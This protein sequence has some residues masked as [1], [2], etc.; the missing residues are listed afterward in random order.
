MAHL[1]LSLLGPFQATLAG[2]AVTTFESDKDRALLAYL[3]AEADRP[4]RRQVLAALLWP[5][6]PEGEAR[7]HLRHTLAKLRTAVGDR[8]AT[9]PFLLIARETIQFNR[10][11][12]CWLDVAAFRE[13]AEAEQV[14]SWKEAVALYRGPFLEGFSL[15]DSAAFEDWSLLVREQLQRQVLATLHRL[16]EHYEGRGDYE[17]AQRYARRQV[18]LAPWYESAHRQLMR[19]LALDNQ[20]GAALAQY[21]ACRR[22]L[23]EELGVQP[24][25]ET[26]ALY[27]RIRDGQ[28]AKPGPREAPRHNLPPSLTPF[29]GREPELAAICARLRDPACRLLTLTGPGGCGKT[30]LALRAAADLLSADAMPEDPDFAAHGVFFVSL[31]SLHS[32]ETIVPTIAQ[33]LDLTFH[34]GRAPRQQLLDYLRQKRM[35]LVLDNFEHLLARPE[36]GYDTRSPSEATTLLTDILKAAPGVRILVTSRARL[37]LQAEQ[38]FPVGGMRFPESP[39]EAA[40]GVAQYGAVELF[41]SSARRAQ[42]DLEPTA[43]DLLHV[44]RICSL[45]QGMP[46][47]ILLAAAWMGMLSPAEIAAEIAKGLDILERD[48]RDVPQRHTSVRAVFGHSWNLLT[49][50]EREVFRGLSVFRGGFTRDAARQV[51]GA[52]LHVLTSLV[53]R[54][55]LHRAVRPGTEGRY[56]VHELLRQYAAEKLDQLPDA[57]EEVRDRHCAHYAS[58]LHGWEADLRGPRRRAAL[59]QI[60]A[61]VENARLAWRWAVDR[62]QVGR[63]DQAAECLCAFYHWRGRLQEGEAACRMAADRLAAGEQRP[64]AGFAEGARVLAKVLAWQSVLSGGVEPALPLLRQS[65]ALLEGSE[66]AD[67]DTRRERAFALQMMGQLVFDADMEEAA[68]L[69]ERSLALYCALGDRWGMAGALCDWAGAQ[70]WGAYDKERS[71]LGE[72]LALY[73]A[74]DDPWGIAKT[75]GMLAGAAVHRGQFERA[76][77]LIRESEAVRRDMD[78]QADIAQIGGWNGW[79]L[80]WLGKLAEARALQEEGVA[81]Y[82]DLGIRNSD[83]ARASVTLSQLNVHMGRYERARALGRASLALTRELGYRWGIAASLLSLSWIALAEGAYAEAEQLSRESVTVFETEEWYDPWPALASLGYAARGLGQRPQ[84]RHHVHEALRMAAAIQTF[85]A[86]MYVLPGIALLLSD[87]GQAE[88]AVELYA[89]ASRQPL[90]ANSRWFEDVAGR[91]I[92]AAAAALPPDVVAAA[93]E[94][95]RSRDLHATVA[96]LLAEWEDE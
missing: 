27:Q 1:S 57:G 82:S 58:L 56:E 37:N 26:T 47:A 62:G 4:H 5:D 41:L 68:R 31:A 72:S 28:V 17:R 30:R 59:A 19:L 40:S 11:S 61:D 89:L 90:V 94:R 10:D 21:E 24:G 79:R 95:G 87:E 63:L 18:E 46:L 45:V 81:I 6:W 67:V 23:Q 91:H 12:D 66:L 2:K 88:R 15:K 74:L 73:R 49:E 80:F 22:T 85:S 51:T 13:L 29:I 50:H 71:L 69:A 70:N 75:L 25:P 35:L 92:A 3:A 55:L 44:A 53:D 32:A 43:D 7:G 65:L 93:Q 34:K 38:L 52:S 83:S 86:L 60:E 36:R 39:A 78:N 96:E 84:A 16:A 54:S 33:A 42:P 9:P 48:W 8:H 64:A 77:R 20:R 76:E 14:S